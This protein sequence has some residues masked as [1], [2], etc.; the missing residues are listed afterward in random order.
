MKT[1]EQALISKGSLSQSKHL[2]KYI[3]VRRLI[4]IGIFIPK[5]KISGTSKFIETKA[6]IMGR[7]NLL[8]LLG[9]LAMMLV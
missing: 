9:D 1:V 7:I 6:R 3:I 8:L 4:S 5:I 2:R